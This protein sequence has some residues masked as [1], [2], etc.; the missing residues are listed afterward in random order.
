MWG[1]W[2]GEGW[3]GVWLSGVCGCWGVVLLWI[4]GMVVWVGVGRCG[5]VVC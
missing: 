3:V 4:G 1:V 5:C 2:V